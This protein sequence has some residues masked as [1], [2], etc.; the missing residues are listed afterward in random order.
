MASQSRSD[1]RRR[2][3]PASLRAGAGF[4]FEDRAG[5]WASASLLAGA[6]P[7]GADF[8][9]LS[10]IR[11]QESPGRFPLDDLQLL[12]R[13]QPTRRFSAS[14]KSFDMLAAGKLEAGFVADAWRRRLAEDFESATELVGFVSAS[15]SHKQWASLAKLVRHANSDSPDRLAARLDEQGGFNALDQRL[16]RSAAIPDEIASELGASTALSPGVLFGSLMPLCLDF[17]EPSSQAAAQAIAWCDQALT[18]GQALTP[19]DIWNALLKTVSEVR[20]TGGTLEWET[21]SGRL[22]RFSLVLRPDARHDWTL[23]DTHSG[24]ALASVRAEVGD[25]LRVPRAEALAVLEHV[26]GDRALLVSGPPGCGKS[27]LAAAW[28]AQPASRALILRAWDLDGGLAGLRTRL[29]LRFLLLDS[30]RLSERPVRILIDGLDSGGEPAHFAAAAELTRAAAELPGARMFIT[31][32]ELALDRV[33]NGLRAN[34]AQVAAAPVMLDN[35]TVDEVQSVLDQREDLRQ[36]SEAGDLREILKRPKLLD[37]VLQVLDRIGP[38]PLAGAHDEAKIADVWWSR[39]AS[40]G[41]RRAQRLEFL[42]GLAVR[43]ADELRSSTS[44]G[45]L[46]ELSSFAVVADELRDEGILAADERRYAFA[47][48]LFADWARLESLRGHEDLVGALSGKSRLPGWHRAIRLA[49]LALL[50]EEGVDAWSDARARLA[51]GPEPALG[52]L[53]LD[54][55]LLASDVEHVLEALWPQLVA[56]N[57]VLLNRAL[58]RFWS[59]ASIPD[60]RHEQLTAHAPELA[61]HLAATARLPLQSL[62]PGVLRVLARKAPEAASVAPG[63]VADLVNLW[64]RSERSTDAGNND[65]AE[66]GFALLEL[67]SHPSANVVYEEELEL[68]LWR[69]ALAAGAIYPQKVRDTARALLEDRTR[70]DGEQTNVSAGDPELLRRSVFVGDTLV[71]LATADAHAAAD[72]AL[73]SA[74]TLGSR[75]SKDAWMDPTR[76]LEIVDSYDLIALPETGPFYHL[77]EL[78]PEH[79][80]NAVVNIVEHATARWTEGGGVH[81]DRDTLDGRAFEMLHNG[82]WVAL[83]GDVDVMHWHRGHATTPALLASALMALEH[84]FY[85]R[86]DAGEDVDWASGK[87]LASR[88]LAL[89]GVAT[90]VACFRPELLRGPLSPLISSAGV[91]LADRL[92]KS[93]THSD[94]DLAGLH[95]PPTRA[96]LAAWNAMPHRKTTL[97]QLLM[98]NVL[99]S[100]ALVDELAQAHERWA[101]VD[102]TGWRYL[103]A[104]TD[105]ANYRP[106]QTPA[107]LGMLFVL[108]E[109]LREE[110]VRDQPQHDHTV[111][112]I[113]FP[114]RVRGLLDADDLVGASDPQALWNEVQAAVESPPPADLSEMG[115]RVRE[116]VTCGL[117]AVL[118]IRHADW[119]ANHTEHAAWCRAEILRA[120]SNP[121]R[122]FIVGPDDTVDDRWDIFCA[123]ALPVLLNANPDDPELRTALVRLISSPVLQRVGRTFRRMSALPALAEDLGRLEHLSFYAAQ[124]LA[125]ESERTH[126]VQIAG[127]GWS[128]PSA[129]D[130]PGLPAIFQRKANDFLNRELSPLAPL[131][132]EF[133]AATPEGL[134]KTRDKRH[135]LA[136]ALNPDY[137]LVANQHRLRIEHSAEP[138]RAH[139]FAFIID[140]AELLADS[141]G[142]GEREQR[143]SRPVEQWQRQL[144]RALGSTTVTLPVADAEQLWEPLIPLG[145]D[146]GR[147]LAIYLRS[148]WVQLLAANPTRGNAPAVITSLLT[149]VISCD[150]TTRAPTE[151][152]LALAGIDNYL[153]NSWH[154]QHQP[155]L[156]A[157]QTPWIQWLRPHAGL[158]FAAESLARFA[159]RPA[160]APVRPTLLRCL[161]EA[162]P[163]ATR[164]QD[165]LETALAELLTWL[166]ANTTI[167][168]ELSPEG[169]DARAILALLVGRGN[170]VAST[171]ADQLR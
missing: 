116:D 15:T 8:G 164:S 74:L 91:L 150:W 5:A 64:L 135:R 118:I 68:K 109:H 143:A 55:P 53:F 65:A 98:H 162:T 87:L 104:Q 159:A 13:D 88:S 76:Q 29:G 171:L 169:E 123:E 92:Y 126:R 22:R 124:M 33:L 81:R 144:L 61:M 75:H 93:Q 167:L 40:S 35:L 157:V 23:L 14:I 24:N 140:L 161:A 69:A 19:E 66:L 18:P 72:L 99:Y 6:A 97:D 25:G 41:R 31:C 10:A 50:R 34:G 28:A 86:L 142:A 166:H 30:L 17:D 160:A 1:R 151:T 117:A 114:E 119:L 2:T 132:S 42:T 62:W 128:G 44:V 115:M 85:D 129:D 101:E 110:T 51:A 103:L 148:L 39:I 60:R 168:Q 7:L 125:W 141:L 52:E 158:P 46:R 112:W 38:N 145:E 54:A 58:N 111:F 4:S 105:P 20:T 70:L 77:L 11:F 67:L 121:P 79:G 36:L 170:R 83:D 146:H 12:S 43:L 57:G 48:E 21:L 49:A 71:P 26:D 156:T 136:L 130:L 102:A 133:L 147:G 63:A 152:V 27:A 108:P 155:L 9:S 139:R 113:T 3:T 120:L 90:D 89:I 47:H 137:L 56:D 96:R 32:S 106:E 154:R 82:A 163:N 80:V 45:D 127:E 149:A 131:V 138:E 95:M 122:S 165:G 78:A 59:V 134:I 84:W 94:L 16:W 107:G 100:D 153:L 37:L 73:R